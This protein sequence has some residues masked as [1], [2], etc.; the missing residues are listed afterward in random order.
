VLF[1][2]TSIFVLAFEVTDAA[3]FEEL[4]VDEALRKVFMEKQLQHTMWPIFRQQVLD[5]MSRLGMRP[6]ALPWIM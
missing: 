3:A 1:Q 2:H 5:G 6:V 4:W